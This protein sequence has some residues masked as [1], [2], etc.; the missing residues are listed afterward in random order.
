MIKNF[1]SPKGHQNLISGLKVTAILLKGWILLIGGAS[2]VDGPRSMGLPPLVNVASLLPGTLPSIASKEH[3]QSITEWR[4]VI[5]WVIF[6]CV[7]ACML[8]SKRNQP[9]FMV[10]Q[11]RGQH[12][13][14]INSTTYLAPFHILQ[15]V[16]VSW[17]ARS[18]HKI[19]CVFIYRA[20]TN[21]GSWKWG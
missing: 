7:G 3:I 20:K 6:P 13:H 19:L 11:V 12:N 8:S 4:N 16:E 14:T 18:L 9:V 21:W 15:M 5:Y 10:G 17:E 2:A 1:L